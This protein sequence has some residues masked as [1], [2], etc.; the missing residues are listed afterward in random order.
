MT[1]IKWEYSNKLN[2]LCF[3]WISGCLHT[4][5]WTLKTL[6]FC[7]QK[8][9][10]C[11]FSMQFFH[12]PTLRTRPHQCLFIW[13]EYFCAFWP[14]FQTRAIE[15]R[16]VVAYH[17]LSCGTCCQGKKREYCWCCWRKRSMKYTCPNTEPGSRNIL[18]DRHFWWL[19]ANTNALKCTWES[20][21]RVGVDM[22]STENSPVRT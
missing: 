6:R 3:I 14:R 12:Y 20:Q 8:H 10:T 22:A 7:W 18:G 1:E 4:N 5:E 2:S 13:N 19:S 21:R 9:Q 15:R 17:M 11:S 16:N